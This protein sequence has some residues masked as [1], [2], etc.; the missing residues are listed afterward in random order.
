MT[1]PRGERGDTWVVMH[2]PEGNERWAR[3]RGQPG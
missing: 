1:P 2:D 3:H